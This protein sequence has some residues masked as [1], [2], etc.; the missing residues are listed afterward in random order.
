[1][2]RKKFEAW[3]QQ[4][5]AKRES[6][7]SHVFERVHA[8]YAKRL[9]D[10]RTRLLDEADTLRSLVDELEARLG[11]EQEKVTKKTDERAEAELRAMV[12]EFSENEWNS[13][14]KKLDN[15]ITDLRAKFDGTERELADLKGL[16]AS[17][18]NAP[19]P[20]RPSVMVSAAAVVEE[21]LKRA[22]IAVDAETA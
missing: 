18:T 16:L 14:R 7:A 6:A 19:A 9:E 22:S 10:V 12:G 8:D 2:E 21:E 4:L 17:V 20:T 5:E 1:G 11:K 13:T 3:I 15:A